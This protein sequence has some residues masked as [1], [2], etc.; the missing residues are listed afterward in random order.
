MSRGLIVGRFQPMHK[1]HVKIIR[2]ILE[3][4]DE[5]V[6]GIGSAQ[7]NFT[8]K[9]P[10]TAG[11]RVEM[12]RRLLKDEQ[13]LER[14]ITVTIPDIEEN[15]V[16]PARVKEYTPNFD[17]VYSGN[18]LV[19]SLFKS[20]SIP[21]VQLQMI[22]REEYEG[23][24]IRKRIANGEEWRKLVPDSILPFLEEI[25]FSERIKRLTPWYRKRDSKDES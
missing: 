3:R 4:E 10:L 20:F 2:Q 13:L 14:V 9:N 17:R 19:L 16:W 18:T 11:E 1:G 5:V 25:G 23:T 21:T 6:I 24:S 22:N 15:L 8:L 7:E 12:I